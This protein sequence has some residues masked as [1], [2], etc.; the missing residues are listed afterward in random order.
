MVLGLIGKNKILQYC[1]DGL[2][3]ALYNKKKI[4]YWG[5]PLFAQL[6]ALKKGK[7]IFYSPVKI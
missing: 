5:K 6:A 4:Y 3:K 2:T 7:A 1:A